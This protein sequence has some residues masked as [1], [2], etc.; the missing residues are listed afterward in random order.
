MN[1]AERKV[2]EELRWKGYAVTVFCPEELRGVE[3]DRIEDVM[4]E[5]GTIAIEHLGEEGDSGDD[6][7]VQEDLS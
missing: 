1:D 3:P 6:E 5:R 7:E 2:I 4:V